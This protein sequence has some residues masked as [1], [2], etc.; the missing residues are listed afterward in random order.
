VLLRLSQPG[1]Y[2][3]AVRFS[4]YWDASGACLIRRPDGMTT[5]STSHAGRLQLSF[6]VSASSA[7]SAAVT[8]QRSRVCDND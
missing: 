3:L 5:V 6:R 4:P 8:G 1:D 2:R 7:L